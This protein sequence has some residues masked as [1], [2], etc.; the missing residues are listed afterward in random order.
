M[1]RLPDGVRPQTWNQLREGELMTATVADGCSI[2]TRRL[3]PRPKRR[4]PNRRRATGIRF[5][6]RVQPEPDGSACR[7]NSLLEP[8][9]SALAI[10]LSHPFA[11][12]KA[13][14]GGTEDMRPKIQRIDAARVVQ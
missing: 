6:G 2:G 14:G 5:A 10:A 3:R 9:I 13:K 7:L 11:R 1:H 8:M 12:E 4:R